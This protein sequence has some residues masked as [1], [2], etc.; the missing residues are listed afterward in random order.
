M[1][2]WNNNAFN[3]A[4]DQNAPPDE[5]PM[6]SVVFAPSGPPPVPP[7]PPVPPAPEGPPPITLD[8]PDKEMKSGSRWGKFYGVMLIIGGAFTCLGIISIPI[9]VFTIMGGLNLMRASEKLADIAANKTP[10]NFNGLIKELCKF[11][12]KMGISMII[13]IVFAVLVII[14]Y[15]GVIALLISQYSGEIQNFSDYMY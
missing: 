10:Q 1:D 11:N 12:R 3:S 7:V 6:T 14:F 8:V 4:T 15:V 5:S 9:G 2:E 13:T